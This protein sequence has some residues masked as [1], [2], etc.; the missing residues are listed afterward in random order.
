MRARFAMR[1]VLVVGMGAMVVL[2][3]ALAGLVLIPAACGFRAYAVTSP[4]MAPAIPLGSLAFVD[5][6]ISGAQVQ[7]DD[8]VAFTQGDTDQSVCVHRAV[9]IEERGGLIETKGDANE[10]PDMRPVPFEEVTGTVRAHIPHVGTALS[11]VSAHKVTLAASMLTL[12]LASA[13]LGSFLPRQRCTDHRSKG[14]A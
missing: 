14:H 2:A 6:G 9:S 7:P 10:S 12:A 1:R 3:L 13:A 8:I 4:S 5:E 11:W